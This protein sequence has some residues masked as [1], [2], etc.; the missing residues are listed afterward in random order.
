MSFEPVA[1]T[2]QR[3]VRG[4]V[5]FRDSQTRCRTAATDTRAQGST[6]ASRGAAG[7]LLAGFAGC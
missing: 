4:D 7:F 6:T 3:D 1:A 2:R 5:G